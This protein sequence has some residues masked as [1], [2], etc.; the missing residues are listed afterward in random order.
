MLH[1]LHFG[2]WRMAHPVPLAAVLVTSIPAGCGGSSNSAPAVNP[3]SGA[4]EKPVVINLYPNQSATTVPRLVV[5]VTS[6]GS[7]PVSMPLIFD[8]G[9]AG[10]TLYAPSIF[11]SSM[12][13]AAGFVFPVR[14]NLDNLQWHHRYQP[15]GHA[16]VRQH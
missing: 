8:T 3:V 9:S 11:P 15:T 16:D 5:M 2:R 13:T 6:V 1:F 4:I 10:V 7:A 14:T 12:V